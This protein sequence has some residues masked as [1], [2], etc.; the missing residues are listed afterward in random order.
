M[1]K[2]LI[3]FLAVGM[4]AVFAVAYAAEVVDWSTGGGTAKIDESG[5]ACTLTIDT[6]AATSITASGAFSGSITNSGAGYTNVITVASGV[7]TASVTTGT[8]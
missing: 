5:G 2:K 1:N 6:V 8:P 7:I 3:S 4:L